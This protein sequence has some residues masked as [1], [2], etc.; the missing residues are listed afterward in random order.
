VTGR[1]FEQGRPNRLFQFLDPTRQ[2]WL[3]NVQGVG[4]T[5]EALQFYNRLKCTEVQNFAI[6]THF[7]I[8]LQNIAFNK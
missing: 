5:V 2:R 3:G 4:S 6:N 8:N 1:S 7:A